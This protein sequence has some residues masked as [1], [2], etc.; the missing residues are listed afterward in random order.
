MSSQ[1]QGFIKMYFGEM[2]SILVTVSK[3]FNPVVLHA[4]G[5]AGVLAETKG[6][7]RQAEAKIEGY[8]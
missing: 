1:L 3:C 2:V 7:I 6:S 5:G 4:Q 8:F